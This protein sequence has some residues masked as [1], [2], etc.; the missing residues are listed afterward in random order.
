MKQHSQQTI[1]GITLDPDTITQDALGG[2]PLFDAP[3]EF[4]A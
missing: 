3:D 1:T 2:V 4:Q